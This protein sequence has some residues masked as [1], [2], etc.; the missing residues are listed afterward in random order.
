MC[1]PKKHILESKTHRSLK[2][3]RGGLECSALI[4]ALQKITCHHKPSNDNKR[5]QIQLIICNTPPKNS[6]VRKSC[7]LEDDFFF[8]NGPFSHWHS[9]IFGGEKTAITPRAPRLDPQSLHRPGVFCKVGRKLLV[10]RI[11]QRSKE[12]QV[13]SVIPATFIIFHNLFRNFQIF[14]WSTKKR[15]FSISSSPHRKHRTSPGPSWASANFDKKQFGMANR[16]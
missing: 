16:I 13:L 1:R 8:W 9:F 4:P 5:I 12:Y 3:P 2:L 14:S 6:P 10:V 11:L 15:T 7:W